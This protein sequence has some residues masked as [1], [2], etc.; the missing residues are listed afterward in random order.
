MPTEE[1]KTPFAPQDIRNQDPGLFGLPPEIWI[2]VLGHGCTFPT[3]IFSNVMLNL[4]KNPN[5]NSTN[6]VRADILYDSQGIFE[7]AHC[8]TSDGSTKEQVPPHEIYLPNYDLR[9][10]ILRK[11]IP[12][13]PQLD[14]P[15]FQT[16][17]ILHS[18]PSPDT[19][20]N[21][22][23]YT[24]HTTT[25]TLIPWYHP[26]VSSLAFLH[27]TSPTST[28]ISIHYS[29]FPTHPELTPRL[30]RTAYQLLSTLH[31]HGTGC[32]AGY[33]KRVHHDIIIPQHRF[34]NTYAKLKAKHAKRLIDN[35]VE[36]TDPAKH[37]FEDL[38]IASFLIEL[39]RDMYLTGDE[40]KEQEAEDEVGKVAKTLFPGFVDIGCGNGVLVDILIRE[41]YSGWGFDARSRKTWDTFSDS[42]KSK[43]QELVLV[44]YILSSSD[45]EGSALSQKHQTSSSG[46]R[47]HNGH[48]PTGTFIISNH[49]DE[50][51]AWTPLLASLT[52]C[53]F[54][55]I[56]CCSHDFSGAKYRAPGGSLHRTNSH[57]N[58]ERA[59]GKQASA[60]ASLVTW[61]ERLAL[62][63]GYVVEK[64]MLRIPSTRNTALVGRGKSKEGMDVREILR[65]EGGGEGWIERAMELTARKARG[66]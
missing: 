40:N 23:V 6:L 19:E 27:T 63:C 15:L 24:P 18:V 58:S 44:P 59:K 49:A 45:Q 64:E 30:Q 37:V 35:W 20:R 38:G 57:V 2:P 56:P 34:Q 48:F 55:I 17:H 41:G 13:N 25:P 7:L 8:H 32:A 12:R 53:A 11:L 14:Q 29:P 33:T 4:I 26:I 61:I 47:W 21:L 60:Y 54:I 43:L 5:I 66:H 28:T 51:T 52:D 62:D 3:P 16:C 31:K 10:T 50:L 1:P 36:C 42:V 22:V 39:W 65:R 46:V 9:R